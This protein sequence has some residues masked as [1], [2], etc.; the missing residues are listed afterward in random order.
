MMKQCEIRYVN[1]DEEINL[2]PDMREQIRRNIAKDTLGIV[3]QISEDVT[4]SKTIY[5][6]YIKRSIDL[7]VALI[8][9]IA[10]LPIN[11]VLGIFT[12]FD[13]GRPVFFM[14]DRVGKDL[15]LFKIIKFRNMNNRTDK[16]GNLLPGKDRVTEFG[17][18]VRKTSLDELLNFWS[19][20]KGDMSLIGPR[21]L[22]SAY[23]EAMSERHKKRYLVRPGLEC[24]D[25]RS[26]Y[27]ERT[28]ATQFENDVWYVENVCFQTDIKMFIALFK[29]VFNSKSSSMR[30]AAIRG[31]FMGY[32]ADGTSINSQ[33]VPAKY[34][35]KENGE[36]LQAV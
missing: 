21:P 34:V 1:I 6:K 28:W 3:N 33:R 18:F 22:V 30:G 4:P 26:I 32:N 12:Y 14:Q 19:I 8:A 20:L 5:A 35:E 16:Y 27:K 7:C 10:T 25:I 29:A 2:S 17:K 23:T 31:S 15:K 36:E 13:V 11:V 24:P 9:I